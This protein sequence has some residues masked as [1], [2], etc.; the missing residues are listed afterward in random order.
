M[1][2]QL[3][4]YYTKMNIIQ[5]QSNSECLIWYKIKLRN[6]ITGYVCGANS[7]SEYVELLLNET[8]K[9][10]YSSK[11][12]VT[13]R[14]LE[15]DYQVVNVRKNSNVGSKKL[16]VVLSGSIFDILDERNEYGVKW[17]KIKTN[18]GIIGWVSGSYV[19]IYEKEVN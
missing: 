2:Q 19:K 12:D 17:Y 7:S 5:F 16:G 14:Q 11:R 1:I 3:L 6:K 13:K 4:D 15:I 10:K 8:D 18:D 9:E